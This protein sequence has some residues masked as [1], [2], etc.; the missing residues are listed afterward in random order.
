MGPREFV[1]FPEKLE[2]NVE[3]IKRAC[4]KHFAPT[5]GND[6]V[7][8][9]LAGEQGPSCKCHNQIPDVKVI[10]V[11]FL[12]NASAHLSVVNNA[13]GAKKGKATGSPSISSAFTVD[14]WETETPKPSTYHISPGNQVQLNSENPQIPGLQLVF[15]SKVSIFQRVC[16]YRT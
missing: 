15:P 9:F 5:V 4:L 13:A 10:H 6:V 12:P 11:R 14:D 16:L 1:A 7:C 2:F 3:N 8:D